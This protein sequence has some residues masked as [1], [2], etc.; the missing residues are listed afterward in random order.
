LLLETREN[1]A[2]PTIAATAD[3]I[4]AAIDAAL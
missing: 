1:V 4:T 3:A 2:T